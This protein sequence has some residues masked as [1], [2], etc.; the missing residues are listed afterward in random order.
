MSNQLTD[1]QRKVQKNMDI[2]ADVC[3][4]YAAPEVPSIG[5]LTPQG[6]CEEL[7][8][9]NEAK[10]TVEKV[11]KILKERIKTKLEP[12]QKELRSDNFTMTI[13][14]QDRYAL[15]QDAA[16]EQ[17]KKMGEALHAADPENWPL[18]G[19]E[20][21]ASCMANTEVSTMRFKYNG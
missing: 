18:T 2:A 5:N 1:A 13:S 7:G 10:K 20:M 6:L 16:K 9:V 3:I 12:G 14:M 17:L 15:V 4:A 11:E 21:L 19:D 8:R